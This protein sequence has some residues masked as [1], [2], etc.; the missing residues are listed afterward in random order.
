[1]ENEAQQ[2]TAAE[3]AKAID[4][5]EVV[6]RSVNGQRFCVVAEVMTRLT[7]FYMHAVAQHGGDPNEAAEQLSSETARVAK[8]LYR[9]GLN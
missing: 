7:A 6:L 1:M 3:E 9:E 2:L 4:L 5:A 8:N